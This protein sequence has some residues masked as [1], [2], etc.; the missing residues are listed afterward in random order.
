MLLMDESLA[1]DLVRLVEDETYHQS[2]A[3][4]FQDM[5]VGLLQ[6]M[7]L[8]EEVF[9]HLVG[10]L[11]EVFFLKDIENGECGGTG[12]MAAT[13]GGAELSGHSLKVR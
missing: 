2:A 1:Y 4:H 12:Q 7:Q 13:K 11:Y 6:E 3:S 10:I 8:V 9:A 5:A